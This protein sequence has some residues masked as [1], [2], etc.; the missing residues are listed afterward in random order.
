MM[1][2]ALSSLVLIS[3][4][5]GRSAGRSVLVAGRWRGWRSR[6]SS[7]GV[8][9]HS[10]VWVSSLFLLK[11]IQKWIIIICTN[12]NYPWLSSEVR[13][14]GPFLH[15]NRV[16]GCALKSTTLVSSS[17]NYSDR[18]N[19]WISGALSV[20]QC[21]CNCH[22]HKGIL[23]KDATREGL[24]EMGRTWMMHVMWGWIRQRMTWSVA[25]FLPKAR[26]RQVTL[27][28]WG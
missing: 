18:T 25:G 10:R 1:R 14:R 5:G 2:S 20:Y 22:P 8:L 27:T 9:G 6:R 28:I 21:N 12:N 13:T 3:T 24:E 17:T 16:I 7:N 11:A 15:H 23:H 19:S 26:A 4:V